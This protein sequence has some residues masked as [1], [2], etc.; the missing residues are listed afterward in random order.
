MDYFVIT[1]KRPSEPRDKT[2]NYMVETW[3]PFVIGRE[4]VVI[5]AHVRV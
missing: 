3:M 1:P 4:A 2:R 5:I